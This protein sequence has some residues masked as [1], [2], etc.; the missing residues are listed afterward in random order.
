MDNN[1]Y[2]EPNRE[3]YNAFA[4][5]LQIFENYNTIFQ[6]QAENLG[7]DYNLWLDNITFLQ[8]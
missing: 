4:S 1:I 7:P 6:E 2:R 8:S 5:M 3:Y